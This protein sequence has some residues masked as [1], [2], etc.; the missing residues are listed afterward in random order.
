MID[1]KLLADLFVANDE[2][3]ELEAALD[4]FC[5]FESVGM[6]NQEIRHG[7]FLSYIF[8]PNRPHGF[9]T[10]C[11]ESLMRAA[12]RTVEPLSEGLSLL[13]VHLMDFQNAVV[14]REWNKIDIL[15][16]VPDQNLI[17]AVE[18]KIDAKEHSKQLG[19]Y[20]KII[21]TEWPDRRHLFLFL[22]K[23][24][25]DPSDDDG[26]GWRSVGLDELASEL[27]IVVRKSAGDP[28]AKAMLDAYL[29]MLGRHHLNDEKLEELASSIWAKHR[30]ALEFLADRRPDA[31]GDLFKRLVDGREK[32]AEA[33]HAQCGEK[34][35]VD[36]YRRAAVYLAVPRW[37]AISGFDCAEGF[38]PTNRLLLLEL[39]KSG[40]DYFRC[41][42]IIG[43][44][45]GEMREKLFR[46][47][48]EADADVGKKGY[49]TKEWN[50]L[51][52]LRISL[53]DV[54]DQDLDALTGRVFAEVREFA[55]KHI[56]IYTAALTPLMA[57]P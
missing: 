36:H 42:F 45:K 18:L 4:I 55:A 11:L 28:A 27:S 13:D 25:D 41:Y 33:I 31:V 52:S 19:R 24:G 54:E 1:E 46:Q 16:D 44:G 57:A 30:E 38:T 39:A 5:P 43:R 51:A 35:I 8:D 21:E 34:V 22:T 23:S 6:V 56:P 7:Y 15:I 9:G 29:S 17:V 50:R 14:R 53:K 32:L 12:T 2:F 40:P 20:R 3:A 10:D 47:L 26:H 49:L 37:D 48:Q